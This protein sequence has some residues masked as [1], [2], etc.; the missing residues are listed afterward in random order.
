MAIKV[1][2]G[3]EK[4]KKAIISRLINLFKK[5]IQPWCH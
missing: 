1:I 5:T 2:T 3:R 4:S